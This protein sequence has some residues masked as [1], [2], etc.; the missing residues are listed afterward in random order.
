[1]NAAEF[2]T[3]LEG[4]KRSGD[5]YEA[6]CP[7][8]DDKH[9][10][11]SVTDGDNGAPVFHCHAG[12]TPRAVVEAVGLT[13]RDVMPERKCNDRGRARIVAEYDYRDEHGVLLFQSLRYEPKDFRQRRPDGAGGWIYRGA[14]D[15]VRRVPYRL[16]ELVAAPVEEPV[17]I[18]EGEKDVDRLRSLGLTATCNPCGADNGEGNKWH[19]EFA[20]HLHGRRVVLLQDNDEPGRRHVEWVALTLMGRATSIKVLGWPD[21]PKGYDV[22]DYLA[23]G[24]S[25]AALS[26]LVEAAGE[27]TVGEAP[28]VAADP[29]LI[30]IEHLDAEPPPPVRYV[31]E[32]LFPE[33]SCIVVGG[34]PKTGKSLFMLYVLLCILL[35]RP[36]FDEWSVSQG[37]VLIFTPEGAKRS[38][39]D[40]LWQLCLGM[41][42]DPRQVVPRVGF[43]AIR[44]G[45]RFDL[46]QQETIDAM[47]AIVVEYRPRMLV[48]DPF[49]SCAPGID[50]NDNGAMSAV[51]S[52]LRNVTTDAVPGMALALI[53]HVT[54]GHEGRSLQYALRGASSLGGW[55]DGIV[56]LRRSA[57]DRDGPRRVDVELRD[58]DA[59]PPFGVR[60]VAALPMDDEFSAWPCFRFEMDPE[61]PDLR[62]KNGGSG[63]RRDEGTL[64][65]VSK[66]ISK[67]NGLL[68]RAMGAKELGMDR[69]KFNEYFNA[70]EARGVVRLNDE[71]RMVAW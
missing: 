18:V 49:A 36:V 45:A 42:E 59:P 24:G 4:V 57:E 55:N 70:L 51:L 27:W 54:K 53:H 7:A 13:W 16:P 44:Q 25:K 19:R 65:A 61:A 50:E 32:R 1:L 15:G 30:T 48:L 62:A 71:D 63:R 9:Q 14:L 43:F 23:N 56:A 28:K 39:K 68:N 67:R 66:L 35:G 60:K 33:E 47:R 40:R 5:G 29:P 6:K 20:E 34:E 10:S 11:L 21:K 38:R 69:K 58:G 12:C 22:S 37:P 17:F 41:G 2:I 31:V 3:R 64:E 8:H 26:E 52:A 46:Q